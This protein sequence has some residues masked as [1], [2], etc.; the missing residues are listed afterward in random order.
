[1]STANATLVDE[2]QWIS[3]EEEAVAALVDAGDLETLDESLLEINKKLA[4]LAV[5]S[6][7]LWSRYYQLLDGKREVRR[8]RARNYLDE[9]QLPIVFE[10]I[11]DDRESKESAGCTCSAAGALQ[12]TESPQEISATMEGT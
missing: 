2:S 12:V 8:R 7:A 5:E 11:S 10:G 6:N 9:F 3:P 4:R 1:M